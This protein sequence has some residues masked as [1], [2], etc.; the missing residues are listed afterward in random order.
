M[1]E[2]YI[3]IKTIA[4]NPVA[5]TVNSKKLLKLNI[6]P[7]LILIQNP[8]SP[9]VNA[10]VLVVVSKIFHFLPVKFQMC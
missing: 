9:T 8:V 1:V 3:L 6:P 5:P 7:I 10:S 2:K 4:M